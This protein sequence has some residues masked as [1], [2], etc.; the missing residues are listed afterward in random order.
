MLFR[1]KCEE[2]LAVG[3]YGWSLP[4]D[5]QNHSTTYPV[6]LAIMFVDVQPRADYA[7]WCVW[8]VFVWKKASTVKLILR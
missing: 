1:I 6:K 4:F 7:K 5:A 3:F 2:V 8:C